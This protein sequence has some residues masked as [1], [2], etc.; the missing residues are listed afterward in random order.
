MHSDFN[1]N[2]VDII[3]VK[4]YLAT[5]ILKASD[6]IPNAVPVPPNTEHISESERGV[7]EFLSKIGNDQHA[8]DPTEMN[9]LLHHEI[10]ILLD[11]ENIVMAFKAGR[12]ATFFT[13]MRVIVLDT[14]G[15]SGKKVEYKSL[16]YT[17]IFGFSATSA[18]GWDRDSEVALLTRNDWD[19]R[20]LEMDFRKGKA[21]IVMIQKFLSAVVLG[22]EEDL[23]N[24]LESAGGDANQSLKINLPGMDSFVSFVTKNSVEVDAEA[25]SQQ[26]HSYPPILLQ[27]EHCEK[28]YSSGR[29]M[30]VY[31]NLRYLHVDTKGLTGKKIKYSSMPCKNIQVFSV[32]TAGH[33]D[34]D[35]EVQLKALGDFRS[36][37]DILAKQADVMDL[38]VYLTNKLLF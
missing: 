38:H 10:P 23:A 19:L 35:S 24:Y 9:A 12:D 31:T 11:N 25:V 17:S 14:K 7:E 28:V 1:K 8:V 3:A 16:L 33:L 27:D 26:L 2:L 22:S 6:A 29:D 5:R 34:R 30:Y 13:N 32:E 21:D 20:L 15:W 36:K 4:K 18:G 37:Q